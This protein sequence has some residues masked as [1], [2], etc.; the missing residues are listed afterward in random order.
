MRS[1]TRRTVLGPRGVVRPIPSGPSRGRSCCVRA[2]PPRSTSRVD[3]PCRRIV[4]P[5][6][7]SGVVRLA[8]VD[9]VPTALLSV[10]DKSGVTDLARSLSDLGWSLVSSGGT[11]RVIAEAGVAVTA[12]AEWTGVPAILGH[13]VG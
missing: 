1:R 2:R 3:E 6:V 10:Y 7:P 12:V 9:G 11:A 5:T 4:D 13:R 8:T